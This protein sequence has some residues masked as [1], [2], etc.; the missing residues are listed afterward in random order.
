MLDKAHGSLCG[1]IRNAATMGIEFDAIRE[2]MQ[3]LFNGTT[4]CDC[5]A[6]ATHVCFTTVGSVFLCAEHAARDHA[7]CPEMSPLDTFNVTIS[8]AK[9]VSLMPDPNLLLGVLFRAKTDITK[10]RMYVLTRVAMETDMSDNWEVT[11]SPL[12]DEISGPTAGATTEPTGATTEPKT[13]KSRRH[14]TTEQPE[15]P[16]LQPLVLRLAQLQLD[17][18]P[19]YNPTS[20]NVFFAICKSWVLA[21]AFKTLP[22]FGL[23]KNKQL[24]PRMKPDVARKIRQYLNSGTVSDIMS[25]LVRKNCQLC[26][27]P[28]LGTLAEATRAAHHG[29]GSASAS[30]QGEIIVAR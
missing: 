14:D 23:F 15:Q 2:Q 20:V 8:V 24:P 27:L 25:L 30:A 16:T 29:G 1:I 12:S 19:V 11:L 13:K 5:G 6:A 21:Q 17:Y 22:L 28:H 26:W 18:A 4:V 3:S 10:Q 7:D 9:V